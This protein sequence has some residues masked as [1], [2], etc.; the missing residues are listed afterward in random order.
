MENRD[1]NDV[2]VESIDETITA[3]LSRKLTDAL[4]THLRATQSIEK[5][6]IPYRLETLFYTLERT[7]GLS[8]SRTIGRAIAKRFYAKLDLTLSEHP[9]RTLLEYVED[10]RVRV[11]DGQT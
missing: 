6:E 3:L 1:F 11:Q 9:E 10:T 8:G 2:L 4:Y 7:F 5:D